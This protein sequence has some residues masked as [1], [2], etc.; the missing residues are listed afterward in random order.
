[1]ANNQASDNPS[2]MRDQY[3][4]QTSMETMKRLSPEEERVMQSCQSES[5]WYRSVPMS[6]FLAMLAGLGVQNGYLA[7]NPR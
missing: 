5:F 6:G 7:S 4:N 2:M 1:M 3:G